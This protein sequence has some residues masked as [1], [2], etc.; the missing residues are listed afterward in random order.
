[1]MNEDLVKQFW[2][3]FVSERPELANEDTP[4][5]VEYFGDGEA[6]ARELLDLIKAGEKTAT[7]SLYR[8]Y[9][10]HDEKVADEGSFNI[11][12]D[13]QGNPEAIIRITD[14]DIIPFRSIPEDIAEKEGEGDQSYEY[15]YEAHENFF[16]R[17]MDSISETF[18]DDLPVVVEQ[19]DLVYKQ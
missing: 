13:Y 3:Q 11:V 5:K 19:F 17:E 14:I 6:M 10:Y 1:M 2:Q 16:S 7:C 12:T 18:E 8:M 15:W 9:E 4:Y